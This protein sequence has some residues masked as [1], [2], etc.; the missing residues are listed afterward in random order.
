MYKNKIATCFCLNYDG[1]TV[2]FRLNKWLA[3]PEQVLILQICNSERP[4][5]TSSYF[6]NLFQEFTL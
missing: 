4:K 2:S 3:V 1:N 5:N 6:N